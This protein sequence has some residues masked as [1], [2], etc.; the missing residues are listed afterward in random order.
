[1]NKKPV[2][3]LIIPAEDGER[4]PALSDALTKLAEEY[5]WG[6]VCYELYHTYAESIPERRGRK[7]EQIEDDCLWL[8][9]IIEVE[10][11]SRGGKSVSATLKDI[12]HGLK[13]KNER[14]VIVPDD[15]VIMLPDA[16]GGEV[17]YLRLKK[18]GTARRLHSKAQALLKQWGPDDR[19]AKRWAR[20]REFA[21]RFSLNPIRFSFDRRDKAHK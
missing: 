14:G 11:H 15:W 3:K 9:V 19:R 6:A 4:T 2:L 13:K 8:W 17:R 12:F 10:R 18:P 1:M 7:Q 16:F 20:D 21:I 5:G